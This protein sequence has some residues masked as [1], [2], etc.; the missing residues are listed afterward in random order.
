ML[1][2]PACV[3]GGLVVG[4]TVDVSDRDRAIGHRRPARVDDRADDVAVHGLTCTRMR[5]QQQRGNHENTVEPDGRHMFPRK[6]GANTQG[7]G[8]EHG[9]S[10]RNGRVAAF[11]LQCRGIVKMIMQNDKVKVTF[12][13]SGI[14]ARSILQP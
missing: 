9:R 7:L 10:A 14:I 11:C 12:R 2:V 13:R 4:S 3:C 1:V 8:H 5:K 6:L